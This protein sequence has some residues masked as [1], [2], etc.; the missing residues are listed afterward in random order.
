MFEIHKSKLDNSVNFVHK[1]SETEFLEARFVQRNDY[2]FTLYLSSFYGCNKG[3]KFCWLTSNKHLSNKEASVSDFLHQARYVFY[4]LKS[5]PTPTMNYTFM[6]RGEPLANTSI[7]TNYR[8]VHGWLAHTA[9]HYSAI[10]RFH[11]STIIPKE[12]KDLDLY[13]IFQG[14]DPT[15]YYSFYSVEKDF[16]KKWLP[17]AIDYDLALQKLKKYQYSSN[18]IVNIHFAF[19]KDENDSE[20][21]VLG[22]CK[23]IK[24]HKLQTKWNIVRYNPND[25][26]VESPHIDRSIEIIKNT[27]DVEVNLKKRVGFDVHASCGMFVS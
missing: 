25:S 23:A 17:A 26:T 7:L 3:C 6:A 20:Q 13:D 4:Y 15:L 5:S 1:H 10:P 22:V 19:I 14:Y 8:D 18:K 12:V 11:I 16:R 24:K 21:N 2:Y 9:R 27:L